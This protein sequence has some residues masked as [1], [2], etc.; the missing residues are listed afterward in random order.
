[1]V[2][3]KPSEENSV[4]FN[5]T[6]S[7]WEKKK[8]TTHQVIIIKPCLYLESATKLWCPQMEESR[9]ERPFTCYFNE[10]N[11]TR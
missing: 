7:S 2:S 9:E 11:S 4:H 5:Q 3:W 1:M 10:V 6:L 8:T